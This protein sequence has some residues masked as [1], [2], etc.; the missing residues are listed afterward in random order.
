MKKSAHIAAAVVLAAGFIYFVTV[1]KDDAQMVDFK[2]KAAA[3]VRSDK[4]SASLRDVLGRGGDK[5]CVKYDDTDGMEITI[6]DYKVLTVMKGRRDVI[7]DGKTYA[8]KASSDCVKFGAAAIA[9]Q[10][11]TLLIGGRN[12]AEEK[13]KAAPKKKS[14]PA[15]EKK[16]PAPRSYG[17]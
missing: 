2:A 12:A 17:Y 9:K 11:G 10:D 14:A 6:Q 5:I 13:P 1:Q 16:K 7:V 3:F 4:K 15:P 8:I